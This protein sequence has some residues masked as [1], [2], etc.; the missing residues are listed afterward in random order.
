MANARTA[1]VKY[2][3]D[4]LRLFKLFSVCKSTALVV[5]ILPLLL[6]E[7]KGLDAGSIVFISGVFSIV[8]IFLETPLGLW[9]DRSGSKKVVLL[10][11]A[12][13]ILGFCSLI[14]LPGELS[15]YGYMAAITIAA[16]SLSGAE[17]SLLLR[18]CS[19]KHEL[20]DVK[21]A[22]SA[23]VYLWTI[24]FL[25]AG[26]LLYK[27]NPLIPFVA[28]IFILLVA[29]YLCHRI[30]V[31]GEVRSSAIAGVT[32]LLHSSGREV[33][34]PYVMILIG[35]SAV[36]A[37]SISLANR[38]GPLAFADVLDGNPALISSVIFVVGNLCSAQAAV[39][40][41]RAFKGFETPLVPVFCLGMIAVSSCMMLSGQNILLVGS[42]FALLSAFKTG[43]RNY[44]STQLI[45]SLRDRQGL[46]TT[47]S[48][49]SII[50]AVVT[51]ALSMIIA[52]MFSRAS[53]A[54]LFIAVVLFVVY[55]LGLVGLVGFRSEI[56]PVTPEN[57]ASEKEHYLIRRHCKWTYQQV[58]PT[59]NLINE[60][61]LSGDFRKT[62]YPAPALIAVGKTM[63]EWE[64]L[65]ST[66]LS[67][68]SSE[69][70]LEA[71]KDLTEVFKAR[72][73]DSVQ[74]SHGDLHPDN[75]L[76]SEDGDLMIVDWDLCGLHSAEFDPLSVFTS[77]QLKIGSCD[78]LEL[79]SA[80]TGMSHEEARA[81]AIEFA[82]WK[83]Q[84]LSHFSSEFIKWV[85][86][87]Y[88]TVAEQLLNV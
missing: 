84:Q 82:Q 4:N 49:S 87:G 44:I 38:T 16:A 46:A 8:I 22:I 41:R 1:E 83:E 2:S 81:E 42:G 54:N 9:A 23:H 24:F 74:L 40:F 26:G 51:F 86:R 77:P 76:V 32:Q 53:E 78:R 14:F 71:L 63:L 68:L 7:V 57:A 34:R 59:E 75:I 69:R 25:L 60:H 19:S 36:S 3:V 72:L 11:I 62:R 52:A 50:S 56:F 45:L 80:S 48:I 85:S 61:I 10:S 28:Q 64:Y 15:Y 17:D 43:Y 67:N 6:Y 12:S 58:Y 39:I 35:L 88:G 79:L 31:D 30:K 37:F 21:S 47:L 73:H 70:Q 20:F 33:Q 27:L 29:I 66:P 18:V 5:P 13:M 65:R 55:G